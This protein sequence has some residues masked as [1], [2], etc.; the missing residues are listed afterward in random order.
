MFWDYIKEVH[1][2]CDNVINE[3]CSKLGHKEVEGLSWT[4]TTD[5]V[6]SSFST[7]DESKWHEPTTTNHLIESDIEYWADYGTSL[8]PSI[9]I[10][11][12]TF[13]G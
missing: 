9:V 1:S 7:P 2:R 4:K 10:N 3:Q 13:R 11:N 6:K 8:F 5:C 12:Q